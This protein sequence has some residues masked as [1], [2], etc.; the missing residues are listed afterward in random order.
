MKRADL[1]F[2]DDGSLPVVCRRLHIARTLRE[3]LDCPYCFGTPEDIRSRR[4][5]CFCDFEPG[6]DPL[7][8]GFPDGLRRYR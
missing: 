3:H 2:A 4:H 8:F 7:S 5:D 6:A 1:P